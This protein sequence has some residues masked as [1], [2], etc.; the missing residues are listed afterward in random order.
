MEKEELEEITNDVTDWFAD[1]FDIDMDSL[2]VEAVL[3]STLDEDASS[4][5]IC[6]TYHSEDWATALPNE[7][8]TDGEEIL[9]KIN[10]E[11]ENE[12]PDY[13]LDDSLSYESHTVDF[14]SVFDWKIVIDTSI[15]FEEGEVEDL[16]E[17][18]SDEDVDEHL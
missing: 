3:D 13:M 10:E 8:N 14:E 15:L 5:Q 17:V 6:V 1:H 7:K 4:V 16:E 12:F 9:D 18:D 2:K 11:I